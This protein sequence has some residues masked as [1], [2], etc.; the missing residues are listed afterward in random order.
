MVGTRA[1]T[2]PDHVLP[3]KLVRLLAAVVLVLLVSA[4]GAHAERVTLVGP[5]ESIQA[6]VDRA[7]PGDTI[8]VRGTHRENV[9]VQTDGLTLRGVGAVILPPASP[10]AHACFDPTE[11]DEAV[12]GICV[13]GEIDFDTGEVTRSVRHVTVSGF[14]VR[15]FTG[16]G[17]I[18][19]AGSG[20]TFT[21][22]VVRDNGDAGVTTAES[23][24][25]RVLAN[26]ASGS[27]F[28]LFL[29]GGV[30]GDVAGNAVHDNCVGV[31]AFAGAASFRIA[32]NAV[33]GNTRACPEA[34][35]EWPA[36]SGVG[37]LL[38]GAT[39]NTISANV[40]LGNATG[41]ETAF[42]GGVVLGAV[43]DVPPS[44]GNVVRRN[45]ILGNDP[46]IAADPAAGNVIA[47]NLC[48]TSTP[49]GLC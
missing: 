46:D 5:G 6:A 36:L 41:G 26:D 35:G 10:R 28:G 32:A 38:V 39:G 16:S 17:L 15:G 9:A 23:T 7:R 45:V 37:L 11:V 33:H 31:F 29:L 42:S 19:I 49:A 47:D 14:T 25:T 3:P 40:I 27:R 2:T 43:A 20:T 34:V 12:H 44:T 4:G 48:R 21:G 30:G 24:G 18:A 13:I 1:M 22:N 8:L